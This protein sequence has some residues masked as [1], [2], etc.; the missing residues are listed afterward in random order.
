MA[1]VATGLAVGA[2]RGVKLS[3]EAMPVGSGF[4]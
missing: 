4:A 1:G 2:A 3:M